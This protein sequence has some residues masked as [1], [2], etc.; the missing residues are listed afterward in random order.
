MQIDAETY[1]KQTQIDAEARAKRIK[2][3][4][5]AEAD[6]IK[7]VTFA[8]KQ[9]IADLNKAISDSNLTSEALQYLQLEAF[10]AAADGPNNTI[11]LPTNAELGDLAKIPVAQ[12]L[13]DQGK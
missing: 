3:D 9:R 10:K 1:A 13:W 5:E 2:I 12:K 11:V 6:R 8:E 4:A 7:T